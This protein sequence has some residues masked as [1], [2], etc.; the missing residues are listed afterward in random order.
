M[1]E[2]RWKIAEK[3]GLDLRQKYSHTF[4][5]LLIEQRH[6]IWDNGFYGNPYYEHTLL[7]QL[8]QIS[9]MLQKIQKVLLVD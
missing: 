9:D 7:P 5:Q 8:G 6:H 3:E 1:D 2:N 4:T